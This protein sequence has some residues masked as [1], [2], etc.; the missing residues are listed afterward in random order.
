[1]LLSII[2]TA[3]FI[4]SHPKIIFIKE[5]IESLNYIKNINLVNE[6][7]T[8]VILSHDYN[9]NP[10]YNEYFKNLRNYVNKYNEE[11][12]FYHLTILKRDTHGHLTG[13]IRNA[14]NN[15]FSKYLLILQHDLPFCKEFNIKTIIDDSEKNDNL[16]Y[17]RFNSRKNIKR[18][19][20]ADEYNFFNNHNIKGVSGN[21]YIS[22]LAWSDRNHLVKRDY[23]INTVLP[24]CPDG[25]YMETFL[26]P[27]N[28]PKTHKIYGTYI[29]GLYYESQYII[30]KRA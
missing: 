20:D 26:N 21:N 19:W 24:I 10:K 1:M 30:H 7:K 11:N 22:T 27:L 16:K 15:C 13:N 9:N 17:I 25:G 29:Y 5:V 28:N 18:G 6:N 8:N 12:D 3:S 23:Y 2:I 4:S 14:I